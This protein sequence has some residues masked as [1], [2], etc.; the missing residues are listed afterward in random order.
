MSRSES[1]FRKRLRKF[2][3]LKRGYYSFL[4]VVVAYAISFAL[5]LIA[6]NKAL[7][8]RYDG[9]YYFPVF[10][11]HGASEFGQAMIGEA[12][13]RELKRQFASENRGNWVLMPL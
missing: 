5:P 7:V 12:D 2:T 1:V 13:Y 8:V 9:N 6:S 11:Y 3:R 10:S 4:L